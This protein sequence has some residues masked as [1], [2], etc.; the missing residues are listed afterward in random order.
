MEVTA[1]P[2]V[3]VD[4]AV[5]VDQAVRVDRAVRVDPAAA[6]GRRNRFPE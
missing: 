2:A 6:A 5:R 1:A 4:R 3:P